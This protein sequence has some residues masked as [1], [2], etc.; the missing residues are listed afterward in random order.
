MS[1]TSYIIRVNPDLVDPPLV[2]FGGAENIVGNQILFSVVDAISQNPEDDIFGYD[3][4]FD[5]FM[6]YMYE[7]FLEDNRYKQNPDY[8]IQKMMDAIKPILI[9]WKPI[10][11]S[12]LT[13]EQMTSM[14][15]RSYK[16]GFGHLYID[17]VEPIPAQ[18]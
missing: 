2:L 8:F 4:Y 5:G 15:F 6:D 7:F 3:P 16:T 13:P 10:L 12:V 9:S 14:T 1:L 18:M 11:A 17:I